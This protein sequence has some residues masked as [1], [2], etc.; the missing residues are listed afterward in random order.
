MYT[1]KLSM[2]RKHDGSDPFQYVVNYL[3]FTNFTSQGKYS[4]LMNYGATTH[5]DPSLSHISTRIQARI[6]LQR[7]I[8]FFGKYWDIQ[9]ARIEKV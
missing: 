6:V 9:W 4:D 1:V 5:F 7:W 8:K 2:A 3:V